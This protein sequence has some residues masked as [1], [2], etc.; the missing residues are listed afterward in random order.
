M[1]YLFLVERTDVRGYSNYQ[2]FVVCCESYKEALTYHPN[3]LKMSSKDIIN[4]NWTTEDNL[5]V[6]FLGFSYELK[7]GVVIASFFSE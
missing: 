2:S 7:K 4:D 5:T 3:G 1:N 6:K